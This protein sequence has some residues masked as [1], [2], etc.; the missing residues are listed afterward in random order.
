MALSNQTR[1]PAFNFDF[2]LYPDSGSKFPEGIPDA[3][4]SP[5]SSH[6]SLSSVGS[7]TLSSFGDDFLFSPLLIDSLSAVPEDTSASIPTAPP[8]PVSVKPATEHRRGR[9]KRGAEP[10]AA[11]KEARAKERV[12]RNR[13]AAQ[14]S[15]DKKRRFVEDLETRNTLLQTENV[16]IGK[17]LRLV[18]MQ[19]EKLN[20]KLEHLSKMVNALFDGFGDSAVVTILWTDCLARATV[21]KLKGFFGQLCCWKHVRLLLC[22]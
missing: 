22:P 4:P 17:R 16:M 2:L 9:Y 14:Q 15:R 5:Y 10:S 8:Q 20:L 18:E 1:T 7:P 19:N 21:V 6:D 11:D 3:L 12:L 13:A